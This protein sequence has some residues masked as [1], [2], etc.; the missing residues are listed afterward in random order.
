MSKLDSFAKIYKVPQKWSTFATRYK[1]ETVGKATIT[2]KTYEPGYYLMEG[3]RGYVMWH[4]TKKLPYTSLEINGMEWMLDDP[5]NWFGMV[6]LAKHST[7]KVLVAGLGLGLVASQLAINPQVSSITVIEIYSD[8]ISLIGKYLDPKIT[9]IN[10]SFENFINKNLKN[11]CFLRYD[12]II[13]DIWV[14]YSPYIKDSMKGMYI[15]TKTAL[16]ENG[17]IFIWGLNDE[18][19]NPAFVDSEDLRFLTAELSKDKKE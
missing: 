15:L 18:T 7:G 10:D 3:I 11:Q 14:G 19:L 8:V 16:E 5:L 12:T 13:L 2:K 4:N 1:P 17:K 9:I 6:D